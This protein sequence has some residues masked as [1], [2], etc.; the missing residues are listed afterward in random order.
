VIKARFLRYT[1]FVEKGFT[2][3]HWCAAAR[4]FG[5]LRIPTVYLETTIFNF[6]FA[7]DAP[8]YKADTLKFFAEIKAG[9]FR[10]FTSGYV[11]QELDNTKDVE[12]REKMKALIDEYGVTVLPASD[13]AKR[14]AGLH[15]DAGIIPKKYETDALH[16]ATATAAGIDIIVSLNF[17]HI[18]KHKTIIETDAVNIREGFKL[19]FIH[20]PAEVTSNEED[21]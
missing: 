21:A 4:G 15:I 14:L 18:V 2:P 5:M 12:K 6:P 16:I 10:P 11:I 20:S 19:V 1:V 8:H 9:K 17:R 13:E 7:D 3:Y